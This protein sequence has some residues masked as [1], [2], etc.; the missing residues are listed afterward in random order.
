MPCNLQTYELNKLFLSTLPQVF[1]YSDE[2][3]TNIGQHSTQ[4]VLHVY[5]SASVAKLQKQ[6]QSQVPA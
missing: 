3:L 2:K 4:P 6:K 1:H 5:T